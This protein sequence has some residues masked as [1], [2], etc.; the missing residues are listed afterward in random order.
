MSEG[1]PVC[2][3]MFLHLGTRSAVGQSLSRLA[4]RGKLLRAGRGVYV[5]PVRSRFGSSAPSVEKFVQELSAQR[6]ET[7]V[8]S[9]ASSANA[10]GL[11]TQV[12]SSSTSAMM[13]LMPPHVAAKSINTSVQLSP[14]V[15]ARSID[16]TSPRI[17]LIPETRFCFSFSMWLIPGQL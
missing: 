7:I 6:G 11:T 8:H 1:T 17:R 14:V 4:R 3:K 5:A 10:L 12:W 13:L 16:S 15:S 2:A 9:G